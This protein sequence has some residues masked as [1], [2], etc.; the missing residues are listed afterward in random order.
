MERGRKGELENETEK[1]ENRATQGERRR[2]NK[3]KNE[4][5]ENEEE[6]GG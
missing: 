4:D 2:E 6:I 3:G 1:S 5:R